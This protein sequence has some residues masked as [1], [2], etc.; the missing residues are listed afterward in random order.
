MV[1]KRAISKVA[2]TVDV[3]ASLLATYLVA[4]KVEK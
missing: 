2:L 1:E 4:V 3:K